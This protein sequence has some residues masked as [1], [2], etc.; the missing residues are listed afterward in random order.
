MFFYE[1]VVF[2]L[3]KCELGSENVWLCE[4]VKNVKRRMNHFRLC[5]NVYVPMMLCVAGPPPLGPPLHGCHLKQQRAHDGQVAPLLRAALAEFKAII[6]RDNLVPCTSRQ[7][8]V[9]ACGR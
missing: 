2:I 9:T 1:I 5:D 6:R 3:W 4:N 8:L 7:P